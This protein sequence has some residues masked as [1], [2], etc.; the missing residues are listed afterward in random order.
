[1]SK[2]LLVAI[3]FVVSSTDLLVGQDIA[4]RAAELGTE[5]LVATKPTFGPADFA[6]Q[7][8]EAPLKDGIVKAIPKAIAIAIPK[9]IPKGRAIAPLS[10]LLDPKSLVLRLPY[11]VGKASSP[12]AD[13]SKLKIEAPLKLQVAPVPVA[14]FKDDEKQ[15]DGSKTVVESDNPRVKPGKVSW[16]KDFETACIASEISDKPVLHF[17]LLGQLDKRFT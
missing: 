10:E 6:K 1:M 16:H 7:V 15:A 13:R 12:N 14:Y 8:I 4:K 2:F 3:F 11:D 9:A 5:T 17:Q